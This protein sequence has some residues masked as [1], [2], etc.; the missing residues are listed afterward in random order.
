M[1]IEEVEEIEEHQVYLPGQEL[2]KDEVLKVDQSAY[3]MLHPINVEWPCLSFD[4]LWDD[5]GED[6]K[7]V[8]IYLNHCQ[9]FYKNL[10]IY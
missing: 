2:Q 4:I 1:E 5:L 6:R 3:E 7:M 8:W 9:I 10:L